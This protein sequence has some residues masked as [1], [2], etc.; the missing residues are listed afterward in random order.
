M[1]GARPNDVAAQGDTKTGGSDAKQNLVWKRPGVM[2]QLKQ[3]G[4]REI[5]NNPHLDTFL[6]KHAKPEIFMEGDNFFLQIDRRYGFKPKIRLAPFRSFAEPWPLPREYT[7]NRETVFHIN[8][9]SFQI[10]ILNK[11]SDI[12]QEAIKRYTEIVAKQSLEEPYSFV[13]NYDKSFEKYNEDDAEKYKRAT[14]L[15]RLA[16]YVSGSD[17][18]YPHLN[19]DETCKYCP[20]GKEWQW[21][22][23]LF[24]KLPGT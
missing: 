19:M 14:P 10:Q 1:G 5:E 8:P 13:N 7:S 20:T 16:V 12:L 4:G 2:N 9:A 22:H 21:R 23:V 24:T 15:P 6:A 3:L 11:S 17:V 18:G